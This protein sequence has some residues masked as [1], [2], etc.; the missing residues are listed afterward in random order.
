[1][2]IKID[3]V[4][5]NSIDIIETVLEEYIEAIRSQMFN[6]ETLMNQH[7]VILYYPYLYK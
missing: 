4:N 1:M 7:N 5:V 3:R 6:K 2:V